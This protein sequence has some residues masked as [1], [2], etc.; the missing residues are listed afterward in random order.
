MIITNFVWAEINRAIQEELTDTKFVDFSE[1][2]ETV[3][4]T[5]YKLVIMHAW[6]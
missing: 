3:F 1:R 2:E 4:Y 6:E 5:M